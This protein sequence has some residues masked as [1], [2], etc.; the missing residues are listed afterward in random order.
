MPG[1]RVPLSVLD[2]R[3]AKHLSK[4]ER[5]AREAGEIHAAEPVKRLAPP[6]WLPANQRE[7]FNR[8]AR[9]VIQ[10]MPTMVARADGDTIATYCMARMEWLHATNRANQA[11]AAGDLESAQGWSLI[12]D[13]YFK[14]A[15]ACAGDLGLT[16]SSR[17][18]IVVPASARTPEENPFERMMREREQ[19]RA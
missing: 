15:R 18:R 19:R 10:L 16:I 3:G 13:R 5:A 11:L 6:K 8:V 7:E 9:A 1:P 2:A 12:Q 14:Q 4:S 17:C